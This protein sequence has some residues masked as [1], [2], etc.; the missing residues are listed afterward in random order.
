M[1]GARRFGCLVGLVLVAG[2][3][4]DPRDQMEQVVTYRA[5]VDGPTSGE[6]GTVKITEI[7]WS[8]SVTNDGAWDRTDVFFEIRNEGNRPVNLRDWR[9]ELEGAMML[10]WRIPGDLVV[11]VADHVF[12]AA[13]DTG[14]FPTPDAIIPNL[15]FPLGDP[16]RLTLLDADEHLIEPAGD[17]FKLP[18]AGGYDLVQSRSME[19]V[20]LMFGG[21]GDQPASW[22]YYTEAPVSVPNNDRIAPDCQRNTLASP[23]RPNSPDYSGAYASGGLD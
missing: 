18:F 2:C 16:F 8:G 3:N 12:I 11:Q 20:E 10:S 7:L 4:T 14:C 15:Q 9:I 22:H 19:K 5:G 13:K 17:R 6:R 1:P 23:G 21:R